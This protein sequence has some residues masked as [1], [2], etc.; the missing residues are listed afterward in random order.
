VTQEKPGK[1]TKTKTKKQAKWVTH[2]GSEAGIVSKR[3]A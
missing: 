1:K 3:G 2:S